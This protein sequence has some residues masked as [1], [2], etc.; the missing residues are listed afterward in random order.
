ML[1][2]ILWDC[3]M[4]SSFSGDSS[5]PMELMVESALEKGLAGICF[6]EH[7]DPDYPQEEEPIDFSLDIPAYCHKLLK[8][9]EHYEGQIQ[10][11][12]GI[13]LGLQPHLASYFQELLQ[14]HSF[15]FVIGSSHVVHGQDPYYPSFYQRRKEEDCYLEYFQSILENLDVFQNMDA[16]GHLDYVVRYGPTRNKNYTYQAYEEVLDA[17]L[18]KLIDLQIG[19]EVNTGGFGYGLGHPNPSEEILSRYKALGGELLTIGA[20]AHTPERVG[21]SFPLLAELL[22]KCGFRYYTVF[23]NRKPSFLPLR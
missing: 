8:L 12:Y 13:E 4:H 19:L 22:K 7:L 1:K 15:D 9:R 18:Q 17:I 10:I 20:D 11:H 6:T 14:E 3:H 21:D 2:N 16:Y 23:R 5:T